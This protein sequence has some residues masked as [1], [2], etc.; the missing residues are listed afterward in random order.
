MGSEI[1]IRGYVKNEELV[2]AFELQ[3]GNYKDE[4]PIFFSPLKEK[5]YLAV[6]KERLRNTAKNVLVVYSILVIR[7]HPIIEKILSYF[8][9]QDLITLGNSLLSE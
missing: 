2:R 4:F 9:D 8:E 1:T 3:L 7:R 5:F 6:K